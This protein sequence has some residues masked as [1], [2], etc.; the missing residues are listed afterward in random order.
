MGVAAVDSQY[1]ELLEVLHI[2]NL[3]LPVFPFMV[4]VYCILRN[5]SV[6]KIL[7]S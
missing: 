6:I 7:I 4:N 5:P 1:I 2:K 3:D